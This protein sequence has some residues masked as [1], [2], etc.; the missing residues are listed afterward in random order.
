MGSKLVIGDPTSSS[1]SRT[2]IIIITRVAALA[3]LSNAKKLRI[4]YTLEHFWPLYSLCGGKTDGK[5]ISWAWTSVPS[6]LF[7]CCF[8]LLIFFYLGSFGLLFKYWAYATCAHNIKWACSQR[9]RDELFIVSKWHHFAIR[10]H[11]TCLHSIRSHK[12]DFRQSHSHSR[13]HIGSQMQIS[14]MYL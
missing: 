4:M 6:R 8:S 14:N 11:F 10:T 3:G 13:I 7:V 9:S 12:L 1:S 2:I 5:R